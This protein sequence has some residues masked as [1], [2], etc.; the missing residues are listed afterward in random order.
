M[1]QY[2]CRYSLQ[3]KS[4]MKKVTCADP[5]GGGSGTPWKSQNIG[6]LAISVRIPWKMTK[7]PSQHSLSGYNRPASKMPLKWHFAGGQ[8][9]ARFQC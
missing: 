6:F 7:L 1:S 3:K 4:A 2:K 8:M 5:E 9:M